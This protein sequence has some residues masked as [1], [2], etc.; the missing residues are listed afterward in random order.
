MINEHEHGLRIEQDYEIEQSL[1]VHKKRHE[2]YI[3][4]NKLERIFYYVKKV[5][6]TFEGKENYES[7]Q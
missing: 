2:N 3:C 1:L 6:L 5:T 7:I 4:L